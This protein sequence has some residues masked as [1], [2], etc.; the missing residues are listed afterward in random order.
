MPLPILHRGASE[1]RDEVTKRQIP[2]R[3]KEGLSDNCLAIVLE[4]QMPHSWVYSGGLAIHLSGRGFS[5]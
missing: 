5:C 4:R 3:H 1:G 2:A